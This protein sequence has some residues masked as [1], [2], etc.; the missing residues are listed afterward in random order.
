MRAPFRQSAR[1]CARRAASGADRRWSAVPRAICARDRDGDAGVSAG[2][3]GRDRGGECGD[4]A[5]G[6]AIS[7]GPR[8]LDQ[9]EPLSPARGARVSE[10]L[11]VC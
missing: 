8:S 3:V 4:A 11:K 6:A 7:T 9:G 2:D 1:M 5:R 10:M